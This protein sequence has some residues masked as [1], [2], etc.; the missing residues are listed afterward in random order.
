MNIT[1]GAG[2]ENE[3]QRVSRRASLAAARRAGLRPHTDR[4]QATSVTAA[5][6][7]LRIMIDGATHE[8]FAIN[9]GRR[10]RVMRVA[11]DI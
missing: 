1:E 8:A 2:D 3:A 11:E 5:L 4:T 9:M 10:R 7:G 6:Q